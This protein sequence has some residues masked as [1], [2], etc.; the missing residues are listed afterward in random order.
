MKMKKRQKISAKN[1]VLVVGMVFILSLLI[2]SMAT[3]AQWPTVADPK[4]I[5]TAFPQQ[6]ELEDYAKQIGKKLTFKENPMFS[7]KVKKGELPAVE[8]RLPA[9]PLVVMPYDEVGKY[10]GKLRGIAIAYESG[11]SEIMAWRQANL[12]RFND[13][14]RTVV[15]NVAKSWK[16][17]QDYTG[18]TFTLRKGHRWSDG[19][20]FTADDVV[21]YMDD[22]ILN[23]EIHKA[24]PSPWGPMG[25]S[26]E[27]IDALTVKFKFKKPFT[28]LLYYLGGDGSYF[29]A[30]A[31]KH[32]LKQYHIKYNPKANEEAKK[33]GFDDW[34]QQFGVYW[35]KWKDAVIAS[36][37]GLKV[38]TL[39]SHVMTKI[40]TQ[41]RVFVANPYFFKIDTA[42]NQLPYIDTH[43]ERF[44]E[45]QLWP[46]E[47]MNGNVDQ[48]SQNM[49]L[50]IYP[51]L[52]ENET[53]GNY[54]LQLPPGMAG[55][56]FIFNM[57]DKDPVLRK[58]YADVRFRYAMSLAINRDEVNETLF[59]GLCT[60]EQALPQMVA[61]V[62]EADKKFMT[63]YD[64]KRANELLDEMGLKRGKDGIRLRSDGKKLTVLW[65]YTLQ[66]VWSPEFP[67]LIADYWRSVGVNVL[68][69]EV[70]T[71]L[72][73]DKQ[74]SNTL[75]I[76]SEWMPPYEPLLLASPENFVPPYSSFMPI[77]G[78]PWLD[79]RTSGGKT[80]E[81][82]P[83][84]VK[85]L[86]EI[87]DE[88]VTL[89]IGSP[90][91]MEL[92]KEMIRI[93]L[94]NLVVIGTLS[95]VPL[96]NVVSNRLGN[97]PKWTINTYGYGYSYPYRANQ[98][99]FK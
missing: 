86:W 28:G 30:F 80:G 39:E 73:R 31:P 85:R 43:H 8:K 35:N 75:D 52:K 97:V 1:V 56:T 71:Q 29:D 19:S 76:T 51:T 81:E 55:P 18:I 72:T 12:V 15:P 67:A 66:Y 27:K 16:W 22:I 93:N 11:T 94:E 42:G 38:P 7:E 60:P 10:G 5:K 53:K 3:A 99:Y 82:P 61:F 92:G 4:G 90:R 14:C 65:E 6:L 44:L 54:T 59:L 9:E 98:W 84:W 33:N 40:S 50:D 87:G 79:W 41:R 34:V 17:N 77:M 62:T 20:P 68:L 23:K 96:I 83:G 57:T 26:V 37:D 21:F 25:A 70:N 69:K 95:D 49:P 36:P 89:T 32:F 88:W 24:T 74:T 64:P 45:K 47:I 91:Y 58:I 2:S 46:L 48:K 63:A 13:D 78:I